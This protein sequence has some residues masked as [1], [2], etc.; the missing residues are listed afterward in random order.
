MAVTIECHIRRRDT[1]ACECIAI[2][3]I[4]FKS[5]RT[6]GRDYTASGNASGYTRS[7]ERQIIATE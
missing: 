2:Q 4:I 1:D 7:Y 6:W 3:D 5:E